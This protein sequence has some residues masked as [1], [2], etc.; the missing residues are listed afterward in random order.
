MWFTLLAGSLPFIYKL[1]DDSK[2]D[3][4]D[5]QAALTKVQEWG[6]H[7]P[8]GLVYKQERTVYEDQ[9]SALKNMPL[10][11]QKIDPLLF[12]ELLDEFL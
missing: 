9:L 1:E 6:D 3:P 5:K 2:Y 11:K 12:E 8:I 7:I 4:S 10:A